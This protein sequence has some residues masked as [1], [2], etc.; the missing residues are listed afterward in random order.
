MVRIVGKEG[1]ERSGS[2]EFGVAITAG[3]PMQSPFLTSN[4]GGLSLCFIC[5]AGAVLKPVT[6]RVLQCGARMYTCFPGRTQVQ[7]LMF[8][9]PP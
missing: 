1:A 5:F 4:R 7:G 3:N 9:S 8:C 2:E 6:Y